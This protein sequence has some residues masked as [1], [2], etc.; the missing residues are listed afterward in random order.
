M[1]KKSI[2]QKYLKKL[3]DLDADPEVSK[4]QE[5]RHVLYDEVLTSILTELGFTELVEHYEKTE[6]WYA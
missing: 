4:D 3:S 2:E 1:D 5:E 6:K